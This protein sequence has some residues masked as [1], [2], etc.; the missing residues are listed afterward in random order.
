MKPKQTFFELRSCTVHSNCI[1]LNVL[2]FADQIRHH[3]FLVRF[4]T[5]EVNN[6][7]ELKKLSAKITSSEIKVTF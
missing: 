3:S 7:A 6:S 4:G 2:H 5:G 1:L